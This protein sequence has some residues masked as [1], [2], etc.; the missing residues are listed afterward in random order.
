M[1]KKGIKNG[2]F[3]E[4]FRS[5]R[6]GF[7][8]FIIDPKNKK[9]FIKKFKNELYVPIKIDTTGSQIVYYSR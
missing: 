8:L 3:G 6:C 4:D 7:I 1:Y 9:K 5:W 2:A